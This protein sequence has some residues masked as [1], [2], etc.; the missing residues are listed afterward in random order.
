MTTR[1][2]AFAG[3][4]GC[5]NGFTTHKQYTEKPTMFQLDEWEH[6]V[7]FMGPDYTGQ[8]E[9]FQQRFDDLKRLGEKA[10]KLDWE[11]RCNTTGT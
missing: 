6:V 2:V 7:V 11:S 1:Y 5:F 9:D 3:P 10:V 4:Q 8:E